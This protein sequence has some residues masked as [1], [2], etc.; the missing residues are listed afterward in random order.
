MKI[1]YL[2]IKFK[3]KKFLLGPNRR[4]LKT[5][6]TQSNIFLIRD[7]CFVNYNL[8]FLNSLV[9]NYNNNIYIK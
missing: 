2:E 7:V 3:M 5:W 1:F 9:I 8:L 6:S 4:F